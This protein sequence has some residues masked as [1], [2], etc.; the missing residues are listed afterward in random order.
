MII[1]GKGLVLGRVASYA[2]K[3]ALEG[4]KVD[5]INC[6]QLVITGKKAF[7]KGEYIRRQHLGNTSY[8]PFY[9]KMPDRFVKRTIR[10]MLPY[11]FDRGKKAME[12]IMC[13]MGV[14]EEFKGKKTVDVPGASYTK[15]STLNFITVND[16]SKVVG[17]GVNV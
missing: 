6:E 11:K 8:G 13:Y 1:D 2:A 12:L 14:P 7:L 10:G 5:I 4:E 3:R 16:L 17:K 9:P 15:L